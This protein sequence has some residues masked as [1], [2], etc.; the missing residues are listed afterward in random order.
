MQPRIA[1]RLRGCGAAGGRKQAAR[2]L[3]RILR[4]A[5][6]CGAILILAMLGPAVAG[7]PRPPVVALLAFGALA[8][9]LLFATLSYAVTLLENTDT[10]A[11]T[12]TSLGALAGLAVTAAVAALLVPFFGTVGAMAALVLALAGNA[13]ATGYGLHR[14]YADSA[15]NDVTAS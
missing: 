10:R 13:A 4:G 6:L 12:V 3:R 14:H 8:E 5:V 7:L 2:L 15:T 11:L 1:M 9:M